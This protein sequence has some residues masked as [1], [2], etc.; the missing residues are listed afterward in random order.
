[1]KNTLAIL[2]FF[3][4]K[5]EC[6]KTKRTTKLSYGCEQT[7]Q[8]LHFVKKFNILIGLE[9]ISFSELKGKKKKEKA[10]FTL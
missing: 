7:W 2:N 3:G 4:W 5:L 9:I 6:V 1:M 10:Q 8:S